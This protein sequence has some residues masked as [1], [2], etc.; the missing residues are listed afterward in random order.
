MEPTTHGLFFFLGPILHAKRKQIRRD[1]VKIRDAV[2]L[3]TTNFYLDY[4]AWAARFPD[5]P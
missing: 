3:M 4:Q 2:S 5:E 1:V